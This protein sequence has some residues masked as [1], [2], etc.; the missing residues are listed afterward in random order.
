V[1]AT[2]NPGKQ[3]EIREILAGKGVEICSLAT[4]DRVDFPDEGLEYEANAVAKARVVAEKLGEIAVA[5]DSGIEVF[6]LDGAPGPLSARYGGESLDDKGRVR[7]LL[8]ALEGVSPADRG[9]RFVCVAALATPDG[10]TVIARGECAGRILEAPQGS[11]GFGYDPVFEPDGYDI[12]MAEIPSAVKNRISH[13]ALAFRALWQR[14][15][16]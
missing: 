13:R 5:D 10:D 9:A 7:K 12:A 14:W 4:F 8:S 1:I 16:G 15:T 11:G 6:A 3:A 2:E